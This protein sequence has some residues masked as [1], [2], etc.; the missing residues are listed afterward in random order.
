MRSERFIRKDS[1]S[2]LLIVDR[3]KNIEKKY[4]SLTTL[5]DEIEQKKEELHKMEMDIQSLIER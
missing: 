2:H 4:T 3:D 5:N 1:M